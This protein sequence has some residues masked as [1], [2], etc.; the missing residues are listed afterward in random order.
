[1]IDLHFSLGCSRYLL[2]ESTKIIDRLDVEGARRLVRRGLEDDSSVFRRHI[3]TTAESL[4]GMGA[5]DT[6][7]KAAD[8]VVDALATGRLV[9][10]RVGGATQLMS[11]PAVQDLQDLAEIEPAEP[12]VH[13][14]SE[15]EPMTWVS[16][17]VLDQ[18]GSRPLGSF[19]LQFE[20]QS[21]SG[22]L[23]SEASRF[24]PIERGSQPRLDLLSLAWVA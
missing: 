2:V 23:P 18:E 17:D 1:M 15:V 6:I 14:A 4:R 24:G 12:L 19:H 10:V 8:L 20:G 22:G 5:G 11:E 3:A 21:P 7:E 16:F 13:P 9:L